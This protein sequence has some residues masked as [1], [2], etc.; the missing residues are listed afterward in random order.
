MEGVG[1]NKGRG[2]MWIQRKQM[3]GEKRIVRHKKMQQ[4]NKK[5]LY[6]F[7]WFFSLPPQLCRLLLGSVGDVQPQ[8]VFHIHNPSNVNSLNYKEPIFA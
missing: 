8:I 5:R 7:C 4:K 1:E 6:F 2:Q 3:K